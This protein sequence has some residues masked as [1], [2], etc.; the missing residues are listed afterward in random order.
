MG[1][2]SN[3]SGPGRFG[4]EVDIDDLPFQPETPDLSP[5]AKVVITGVDGSE[6]TVSAPLVP[7]SIHCRNAFFFYYQGEFDI[8]FSS[9]GGSPFDLEITL[10]IRGATYVGHASWRKIKGEGSM[11]PIAFTPPLPGSR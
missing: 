4:L 6:N 3:S 2:F 11:A 5:S 10:S 8:P 7:Q 9:L 1:L